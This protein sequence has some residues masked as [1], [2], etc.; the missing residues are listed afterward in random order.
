MAA[1]A[2]LVV[3]ALDDLAERALAERAD[4]LVAVEDVVLQHDLVV[5]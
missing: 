5:A 3:Q 1:A 2:G 4:H